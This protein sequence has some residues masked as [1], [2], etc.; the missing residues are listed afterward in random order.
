MK[1]LPALLCL[2]G[3]LLL[4]WPSA[5]INPASGDIVDECF[6]TMEQLYRDGCRDT[7]A[8]LRSGEL[9]DEKQTRDFEEAWFRLTVN[10]ATEPIR[11][12]DAE[13]LNDEWNPEALAE[14]REQYA[15]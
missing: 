7:A 10:T 5:G 2:A 12:R 1:N 6:D 15:K 3:G 13:L 8:R 4:L 11:K 14:L 9:T